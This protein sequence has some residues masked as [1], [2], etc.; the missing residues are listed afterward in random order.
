MDF[1]IVKLYDKCDKRWITL[2][3]QLSYE[4]ALKVYNKNTSFG[5]HNTTSE[6]GDYFKIFKIESNL[7]SKNVTTVLKVKKK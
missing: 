7:N 1:F 6:H 4:E 5:M 3:S 2:T